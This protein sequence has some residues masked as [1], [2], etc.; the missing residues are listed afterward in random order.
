MIRLF[1]HIS[2]FVILLAFMVSAI[3]C[4]DE[5]DVPTVVQP[6]NTGVFTD[7]RDGE[8]YPWVEYNGTQWMTENYRYEINSY[9]DCR[10]YIE[11][12]DW[13]DYAAEQH[14]TRNRAK[15]GMYYT[16]EGALRACPEG[17]RLPTD[18]DWQKLEMA[19]GMSSADVSRF[20][21]RGNIAQTMVSTK[22]QTTYT[23]FLL[24]GIVTYHVYTNLR[25]GSLYKGAWG[26]YWTNST[27]KNKNGTFYIY[28][29]LAYNRKE[30][31]RQSM[32]PQNQLLSV[33]YCRDTPR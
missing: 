33:R 1:K 3:S 20:E 13:V 28:R 26:Y 18:E 11:D 30:I 2:L 27:D 14:A 5:N 16:L 17:W 19:M 10:N 29:K 8:Q 9:A 12:R 32:E 31:F 22:D 4:K 23:N 15:Y 6:S 25:N 7:P 21:W 24:G